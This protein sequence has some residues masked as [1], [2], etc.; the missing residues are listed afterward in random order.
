M[1]DLN[2]DDFRGEVRA[3]VGGLSPSSSAWPTA[4]VDRWINWAYR[5]VAQPRVYEH[6]NLEV[7]FGQPLA[8]NT[9]SYTLTDPASAIDGFFKIQSVHVI[10]DTSVTSA[11]RNP[12]WSQSAHDR[13]L[14]HTTYQRLRR[15]GAPYPGPPALWT[16]WRGRLYID[17]VPPSSDVGKL[18]L[19]H[20]YARP[21]AMSATSSVTAM[22]PE[23]DEVIT[24]GAS[25]RGWLARGNADMAED[26]RE[27]FGQ[28][29]NE[30]AGQGMMDGEADPDNMD[31]DG[32]DDSMRAV[33]TG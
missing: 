10:D 17:K 25:W 2:L 30:V 15:L 3:R 21:V 16:R 22:D 20:G 13:L 12:T 4:R 6:P 1:G 31:M 5:W 28:L 14:R 7:D 9:V 29:V 18:L 19:L 32:H 23:W 27:N 11:T 26:A 33:G 8:T 24:V